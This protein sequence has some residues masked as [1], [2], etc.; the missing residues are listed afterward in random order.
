VIDVR[1]R[2][3]VAAIGALA[4]IAI[5]LFFARIRERALLPEPRRETPAPESAT[6]PT[7]PLTAEA[8][9]P[10]RPPGERPPIGHRVLGR[11][12]VTGESR[13]RS[14]A[15][16][17]RVVLQAMMGHVPLANAIAQ[18]VTDDLGRFVFSNVDA[19]GYRIEASL[20]GTRPRALEFTR[21]GL[22]ED[23][24]L[25]GIT[26]ARTR[27][28]AGRVRNAEGAAIAGAF[29]EIAPDQ[30]NADDREEF[31]T[32]T[33]EDGSFRLDAPDGSRSVRAST[34]DLAP[35][36]IA[37]SDARDWTRIEI[38]LHG[39]DRVLEGTVRSL[40][41]FVV[42]ARIRTGGIIEGVKPRAR[43]ASD[44]QGAFELCA[45][46]APTLAAADAPGFAR[47]YRA[48]SW[49][50]GP[51]PG[52]PV[53][54]RV[55]FNLVPGAPM[56]G[57]VRDERGTAVGGAW[58]RLLGANEEQRDS[59]GELLARAITD[60]T[61]RFE[62]RDAP[63]RDRVHVSI[64][65]PDFVVLEED[66]EHAAGRHDFRLGRGG[67][68]VG[69]VIDRATGSPPPTFHW[70]IGGPCRSSR[71]PCPRGFVFNGTARFEAHALE[72]GTYSIFI[73]S[74]GSA[75]ETRTVIVDRGETAK[76]R[77]E[78]AS[79]EIDVEGRVVGDPLPPAI[80][81]VL[82]ERGSLIRELDLFEGSFNARGLPEGTYTFEVHRKRSA[83]DDKEAL[84]PSD[85]RPITLRAG[86]TNT[87]EIHLAR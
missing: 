81:Y 63:D 58:V 25:L 39:C 60:A 75:D 27:S 45:S 42:G 36:S 32:M 3:A 41:G 14:A 66:L 61:G 18:T 30:D 53:R 23:F 9:A 56:S 46:D 40:D 43:V 84:L 64:D 6:A 87:I 76:V 70:T 83:P 68:I 48:I 10:D 86:A 2:L 44:E 47:A 5:Y 4:A 79:A 1:K 69:E 12:D 59:F 26:L 33:G 38:V 34:L 67:R 52:E 71:G 21:P 7:E 13:R 62:I 80:V 11:V 82:D 35:E 77:I 57:E 19:G 65:H 72:A 51:K 31:Y 29:V 37:L 20:E 55:N 54:F 28:V 73:S 74:K 17:A 15:R 24:D 49:P 22:D 8:P 85:S 50:V 78:L 16:G